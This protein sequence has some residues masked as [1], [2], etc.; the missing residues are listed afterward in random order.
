MNKTMISIVAALVILGGGAAA[1]V[2]TRGN[3][4]SNN[5][6]Q[7][8]K[9]TGDAMEK[10]D[11][12]VM[13]KTDEAM[14]KH[15]DTAMMKKAESYTTLAEFEGH[16]DNYNDQK[17][18]LFFH[19]SW[20]P[21]C[22]SIDEDITSDTSQIPSGTSFIKTDFD[23]STELRQKYGVTTQYTFVQIDNNGNEIAQWSATNLDKAIAGIN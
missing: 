13:E 1:F 10:K 20:C 6:A 21:I 4:S 22:K 19:A 18:V 3:E 15:D 16:K 7:T 2:A 23:T 14:E 9:S 17:K 5:Q 11:S 8:S 12:E